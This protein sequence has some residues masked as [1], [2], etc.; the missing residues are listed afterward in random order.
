VIAVLLILAAIMLPGLFGHHHRPDPRIRCLNALRQVGLAFQIWAT[1]H[2]GQFPMQVS[3]N[4]GGSLEYVGRPD[5]SYQHF[6]VMAYALNTP[7][8][9]RCP[10]DKARTEANG[11]DGI[12]STS[13]PKAIWFRDNSNLSYFVGVDAKTNSAFFL[14]GD[15]NLSTR[16][17]PV[18]GILTVVP[19]ERAEWTRDL[20][21]TQGNVGMTD[22]SVRQFTSSM[23]RQALVTPGT[24]TNRL[25]L[26]AVS[27][28]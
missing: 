19:G 8:L 1:D 2:N 13:A 21:D 22:G 25:A 14:A 12:G 16:T 17:T 24:P 5:Q 9:L 11:F 7:K 26:P 27:R 10:A 28:R 3:T 18:N 23:L 6:N 20:H 15:R 4:D